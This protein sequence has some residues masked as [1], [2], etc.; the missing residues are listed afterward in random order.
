MAR[1][2]VDSS[3]EDN[4][5]SLAQLLQRPRPRPAPTHPARANT[6]TLVPKSK[7]DQ[8]PARQ[9]V[10]NRST[11]GSR[12]LLDATAE[13]SRP[14]PLRKH[15]DSVKDCDTTIKRTPKRAAAAR[16]N[17]RSQDHSDA[18]EVF[19]DQRSPDPS[20][21]SE[22]VEQS[23]WCGDEA[24]ASSVD[25]SES[26]SESDSDLPVLKPIRKVPIQQPAKD[27]FE[28]DP[29]LDS[30]RRR[31]FAKKDLRDPAPAPGLD[32]IFKKPLVPVSLA[33]PSPNDRPSSSSSADNDAILRYSPPRRKSPYKVPEASKSIR[34][35][36]PPPPKSPVKLKSPS[37]N[38][39]IPTP[40]HRESLDA[41]WAADVVNDWNDQH[42]PRKKPTA[43]TS[44]SPQKTS[45]IKKDKNVVLER[46]LFE[47]RK[48]KL[49]EEFLN[50]LDQVMTQGKISQMTAESG[51]I[52]LV[53]SKTLNQTAGRANWKTKGTKHI[54]FIELADKV[55]DD[56]DK[57]VNTLAH[58][59]C[60][61]ANYMISGVKDNPH[62]AQFK[63]WGAKVSRA[64]A[65]RNIE[66]TTKHSYIIDYKYIWTC[67]GCSHEYKRHSKSI[68][69]AKSRC[70]IC[71]SQ[72][73]Q[74]KPV[75]RQGQTSEYHIFMKANFNRIKSENAGKSH[76]VIMELVGKEYREMK[77]K[78]S[79]SDTSKGVKD[80]TDALDVIELDD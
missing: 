55:V 22:D 71:K 73:L 38:I 79:Q 50:E 6:P 67:T 19:N 18:E 56:E 20:D 37:K 72:L 34:S 49:A 17:Y 59:Y 4:L 41:F 46:K 57:M 40:P 78:R 47:E 60:H 69:L 48:H 64:F 24:D 15:T 8:A 80:L 31:L 25:D 61:L 36:T 45:P 43:G 42:S 68:N 7:S 76:A 14:T 1:A 62:G 2:N 65:H 33:R 9:R 32:D 23:I 12:P 35:S 5:P 66:V 11:F 75:P 26:G 30:P 28:S 51:G 52:K 58:E 63:A 39:R 16:V 53:W 3:D 44:T 70:G 74:T 13:E 29:I 77:A 10:L 54:V 27:I 21:D